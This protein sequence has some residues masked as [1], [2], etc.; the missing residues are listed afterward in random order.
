MM[1]N[2]PNKGII[3]VDFVPVLAFKQPFTD[4]STVVRF[5]KFRN[6]EWLAIPKPLRDDGDFREKNLHWRLSFYQQEREILARYGRVKP[7]IRQMKKLRD[8]QDWKCIASYYIETL[9]LNEMDELKEKLDQMPMTLLFFM[10]LKKL[11]TC[12]SNLR[13]EYYWNRNLNLIGHVGF[14]NLAN[15]KHRLN[16]ILSDIEKNIAD[17]PFRVAKYIRE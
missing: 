10:M 13:I 9:F 17:D 11:H 3:C 15:I 5:D 6:K 14:V 16:R 4:G 1:L 8:T 7:V 2:I 12:C